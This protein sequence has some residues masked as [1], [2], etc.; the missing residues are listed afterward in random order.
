MDM[1]D[2]PVNCVLIDG[3]DVGLDLYSDSDNER[4]DIVRLNTLET[5]SVERSRLK[6]VKGRLRPFDFNDFADQEMLM[7]RWLSMMSPCKLTIG[8]VDYSRRA[9]KIVIDHFSYDEKDGWLAA[10]NIGSDKY[11]VDAVVLARLFT[12]LNGSPCATVEVG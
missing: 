7:G 4:C 9:T 2:R 3:K 6:R 8:G 11:Y 5:V 10:I 12:F 1:F